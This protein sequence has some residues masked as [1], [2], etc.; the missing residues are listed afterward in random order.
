[1]AK[2]KT[3]KNVLPVAEAGYSGGGSELEAYLKETYGG[4]YGEDYDFNVSVS[5][6]LV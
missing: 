5:Q 1:M 6:C 4:E 3:Y 2:Q